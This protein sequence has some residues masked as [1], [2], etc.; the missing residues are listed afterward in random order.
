MS[1]KTLKCPR[2]GAI[3]PV[4]KGQCEGCGLK[5]VR[6]Q[7]PEKSPPS[8]VSLENESASRKAF[9]K[10]TPSD[11]HMPRLHLEGLETHRHEETP[12]AGEPGKP[13]AAAP[14]KA[15]PKPAFHREEP[16][17]ADSGERM[18]SFEPAGES[19]DTPAS[20]FTPVRGRPDLDKEIGSAESD[21]SPIHE[22]L[23]RMK[24]EARPAGSELTPFRGR[25]DIEKAA[26]G[27][28]ESD[29]TPFRGRV[30][31]E[32]AAQ[33][34]D[35]SDL[36]PF[37]PRASVDGMRDLLLAT[38]ET[39]EPEGAAKPRKSTPEE[40]ADE[41]KK[42]ANLMLAPHETYGEEA[43]K[44]RPDE[45]GAAGPALQLGQRYQDSNPP[46]ADEAA[47][48]MRPL[49]GGEGSGAPPAAFT[50]SNQPEE[51]GRMDLPFDPTPANAP[52]LVE[53]KQKG[54]SASQVEEARRDAWRL[55]REQGVRRIFTR[56]VPLVVVIAVLWIA[57]KT[58]ALPFVLVQ[59]EWNGKIVDDE[60]RT[61]PVAISFAREGRRLVGKARLDFPRMAGGGI[62]S[63]KTPKV[64]SQIFLDDELHV[65]GEF[66]I[67]RLYLKVFEKD[68]DVYMR[69][70]GDI[71]RD[72]DYQMNVQG[73][74]T[75]IED[76][77]ARFVLYRTSIR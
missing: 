27:A 43:A 65:V 49:G 2:C 62:D 72:Q 55:R 14:E 70:V 13:R 67:F 12:A 75:N 18:P 73:D 61:V 17:R 35:E 16:F 32:K 4:S 3:T 69:L 31:I 19:G 11:M 46:L 53:R 36:T 48:R 7:K 6:K 23:P 22:S 45:P 47:P 34:A 56:F 5:M 21:L 39:D 41:A 24:P 68:P 63:L 52:R 57:G 10:N 15:A 51:G 33:G 1:E 40:D 71:R 28:D 30:D 20:G 54:L 77:A 66:D 50:H 44:S 25:V 42:F 38:H 37:R 74:A 9:T 29:L 64:L 59:G 60:G 8:K 26:Q 76:S 58:W